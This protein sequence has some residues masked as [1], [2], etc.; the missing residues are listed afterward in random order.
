VIDTIFWAEVDE[1][2]TLV[3]SEINASIS[4]LAFSQ[5]GKL[6]AY[7]GHAFGASVVDSSTWDV[8]FT[9]QNTREGLADESSISS[10]EEDIEGIPLD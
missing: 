2:K 6:I 9:L 3:S 8:N 5:D 4:I 7:G 10:Q 1:A